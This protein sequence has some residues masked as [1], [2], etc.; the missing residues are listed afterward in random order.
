V[1]RVLFENLP[2]AQAVR[3]LM[4]RSVKVERVG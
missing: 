4:S 3:E 2:P 1:Y